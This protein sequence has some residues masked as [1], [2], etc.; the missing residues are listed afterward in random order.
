MIDHD[1]NCASH[2]DGVSDT[3][4]DILRALDGDA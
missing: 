1:L 3:A 2:H 4:N